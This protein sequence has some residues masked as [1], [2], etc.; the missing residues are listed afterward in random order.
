VRSFQGLFIILGSTSAH[1]RQ[2]PPHDRRLPSHSRPLR[3]GPHTPSSPP[4]IRPFSLLHATPSSKRRGFSNPSAENVCTGLRSPPTKLPARLQCPS[5]FCAR[6]VRLFPRT[7]MKVARPYPIGLQPSE[8]PARA[9]CFAANKPSVKRRPNPA[10]P[11]LVFHRANLL[12]RGLARGHAAGR[13]NLLSY[14]EMM[15]VSLSQYPSH[16][17][18]PSY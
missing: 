17:T 18:P 8:Y 13:N 15:E 7:A 10:A 6:G 16:S 3:S 12:G 4:H 2:S 1:D 11:E 14:S 9:D 5:S